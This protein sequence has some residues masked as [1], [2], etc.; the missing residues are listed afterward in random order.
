MR[1]GI[2]TSN[3][4]R[5]RYF[6]NVMCRE[7]DVAA[8]GYQD[9]AYSPRD[10]ALKETA[11]RVAA[12]QMAEL[13]ERATAIVRHHF[14]ER[15]RQ[16]QRFFGHDAELR[17]DA[18]TCRVRH[19]TVDTLNSED[20]VRWLRE[21]GVEAV[22]VYGTS[23]V[24]PPLLDAY[25]GRMV[26]MHLGLS[27]YYRG[28]A[29][30]FYP[31]VNNEPEYVGVTIHHIDAGIDSGDIIHHGRAEATADDMPHTF[32]CKTIEVGTRLMVRTV[33]ELEAGTMKSVPQWRPPN[34]RLY[35]RKDYHPEQVV[36]L[37]E[38]IEDGMFP[39]YAARQHE[40]APRVKLVS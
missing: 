12:Q 18:P 7:L 4:I 29:T 38:L 13:N 32:G 26:N 24:K 37:Y 1:I 14:E 40:V 25:P 23:L 30:N 17:P 35:Q 6:V 20:T 9:T 5:H 19:L 8:V 34:S 31:L 28:N 3:D 10:Q 22:V 36:R 11:A 15:T 39:K 2:L 16:E 33:R 27:P 21:A